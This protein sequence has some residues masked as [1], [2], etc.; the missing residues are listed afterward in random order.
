MSLGKPVVCI[1]T[2]RVLALWFEDQHSRTVEEV[3]VILGL[4][5]EKGH[6]DL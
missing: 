4:W 3:Q 2:R 6:L 5:L 1:S